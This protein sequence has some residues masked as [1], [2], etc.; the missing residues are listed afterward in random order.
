VNCVKCG[1]ELH[2]EQKV[3]IQCGT[4][5]AAGGHFHIEE[6]Q[7]WKPSQNVKYAALMVALV[8]IIVIAAMCLKVVPPEIVTEQWFNLMVGRNYGKAQRF[9]SQ[10]FTQQMEQTMS[11]TRAVS[12]MI[13][14]RLGGV[15][16]P[17]TFGAPT[18]TAPGQAT[19]PVTYKGSDG[20]PGTITVSLA[21]SGRRWLITGVAY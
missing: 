7:A 13:I 17:Y 12:D 6:K 14:D 10:Q 20:Q 1:A 18:I 16:T 5:T 3:C 19:V 15:Q 9:H 11:D 21:K 8:L 2:E 4:R